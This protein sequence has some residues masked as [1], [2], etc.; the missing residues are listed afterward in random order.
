[1]DPAQLQW[2]ART[3]AIQ[4]GRPHGPG[5][6]INQAIVGV[7]TYRAG[8]ERVY[9]RGDSTPTWEALEEAVGSL[10]DGEATAFASGMAAISSVLA[11]WPVGSRI[12]APK[13]CYQG[14]T[15][16]LTNG[17]ANGLWSVTWLEPDDTATWI[18]AA[19]DHDL[20]WLESPTNPLLVVSDLP[21]ILNAARDS[22]AVTVVDNTFATPLGQQPLNLGADIVVHS[23]TKFL[24]G[25]SDLLAG[26]AVT[27]SAEHLQRLRQ[28]RTLHG[29]TPGMLEAY[30]VTRGIRTLPL[31]LAAA[32][33]SAQ[34]LAE[35]L[36]AHPGVIGVRF[37][38]LPDHPQHTL[39]ASFMSGFGAMVSFEV[40]DAATADRVCAATSLITHATSLGGVESTFERRAAVPGQEHLPP[41]LIR[42]SVGC[43]SVSDLWGDLKAALDSATMTQSR[44]SSR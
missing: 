39:A 26:V 22:A 27:R 12:A 7:S 34:T 4:A 24:G 3:R 13:D 25:H 33:E 20:L 23:A 43:E 9:S 18:D 40:S 32:Q 5:E 19:A 36:A 16:L 1:M 41:G 42:L 44:G 21:N 29:G 35:R 38:G 15:A 8:A 28:A 11:G 6:P 10:E 2:S 30:L 17:I 14:V 37:P 31:R